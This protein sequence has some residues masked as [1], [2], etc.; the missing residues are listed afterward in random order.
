MLSKLFFINL[1][2]VRPGTYTSTFFVTGRCVPRTVCIISLALVS[3]SLRVGGKVDSSPVSPYVSST[4]VIW[5]LVGFFVL[6]GSLSNTLAF[7][8]NLKG[9]DPFL[10]VPLKWFV[11]YVLGRGSKVVR[12]IDDYFREIWRVY[13][14]RSSQR[15]PLLFPGCFPFNRFSLAA[16]LRA[17]SYP[18]VPCETGGPKFSEGLPHDC[19]QFPDKFSPW[20]LVLSFCDEEVLVGMFSLLFDGVYC[21]AV[22]TF[23]L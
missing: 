7:R 6:Q 14:V 12:K 21:V 13:S 2:K 10:R 8:K 1:F 9:S 11:T 23:I 3:M 17:I 18:L 20:L 16:F 15:C 22:F 4:V 5:P 19:Y